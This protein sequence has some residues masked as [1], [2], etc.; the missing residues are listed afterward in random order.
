[1]ALFTD[2]RELDRQGTNRRFKPVKGWK[3]TALSVFGYNADGTKNSFGKTLGHGNVL[4]DHYIPKWIAGKDSDTGQV[5]D[6]A[7]DEEW[8]KQIATAKLAAEIVTFGAAS[9]A[10]SAAGAAGGA[11]TAG[12]TAGTAG[13]AAGT[14]TAGAVGATGAA[15][16]GGN[17]GQAA[18]SK[19]SEQTAKNASMDALNSG[20]SEQTIDGVTTTS[21]GGM[22]LSEEDMGKWQKYMEENPEGTIEDFKA[23][24]D[25]E[26]N[27][28]G[29]IKAAEKTNGIPFVGNLMDAISARPKID[30]KLRGTKRGI[31]NQQ[32]LKTFNYL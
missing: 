8:N 29:L 19:A 4:M 18:M 21:V 23:T 5:I 10:G 13:T 15:T 6:S 2:T 27:G 25:T 1:M 28:E 20:Y 22:D 3:K 31:T 32:N 14:S 7:E 16:A 9:G 30:N 24:Q 17:A 12:A 11:G 26:K